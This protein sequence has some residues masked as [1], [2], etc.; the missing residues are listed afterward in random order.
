MKLAEGDL[1]QA[2]PRPRIYSNAPI[3][4]GIYMGKEWMTMPSETAT[5][6]YLILCHDNIV[7][8]YVNTHTFHVLQHIKGV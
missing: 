5:L 1:I 3:I 7:P 8:V 6:A 4:T 2:I